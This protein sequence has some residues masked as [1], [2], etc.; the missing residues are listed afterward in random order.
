M[1]GR[2]GGLGLPMIEHGA[3]QLEANH[4]QASSLLRRKAV[5]E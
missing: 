2:E 3:S 1:G 4:W 5:D